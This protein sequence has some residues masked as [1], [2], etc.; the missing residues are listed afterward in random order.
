MDR[1]VV[2]QLATLAVLPGMS[3]GEADRTV[4]ELLSYLWEHLPALMD[5]RCPYCAGP[6]MAH[7]GNDGQ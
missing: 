5:R 6:M 2:D 3:T 4:P 7:G 1:A